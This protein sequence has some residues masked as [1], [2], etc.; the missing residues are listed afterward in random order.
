MKKSLIIT[1]TAILLFV[2]C[3]EE[4]KETKLE[5]TTKQEV[6]QS[7]EK[8]ADMKT[9]EAKVEEKKVEEVKTQI[10]TA[11]SDIN[12]ESLFKTCTSCH[13]AKGEKEALGKSQII[14]GWDKERVMRA[15]N[16]YKD[17]SYGGVMKGIMKPH[18]ESKT[19]EQIEISRK[20]KDE[21][22]KLGYDKAMGARPLNRV[23][24]QKVKNPLT[25]EILFG[26]LKKG[27]VVKIDFK[28]DFVFTYSL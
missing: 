17:G 19:P 3:T 15:L 28:E 22:A 4:K 14:A 26:K 27:G 24:S 2:G 23:I 21:L 11:S 7:V 20:A 9:V 13:G 1:T 18:V 12:G 25:D 6:V 8:K 5:T 10:T 16:G